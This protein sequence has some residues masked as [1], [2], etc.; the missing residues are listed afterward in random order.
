MTSSQ[1]E[2]NESS[3]VTDGNLR[4]RNDTRDGRG[5]ISASTLVVSTPI[6]SSA[7]AEISTSGG[8]VSASSAD[9]WLSSE[10]SACALVDNGSVRYSNS[11]W[12]PLGP[13]EIE[14]SHSSQ[15]FSSTMLSV[16]PLPTSS[17]SS[18][19][20]SA[21]WA[22]KSSGSSKSSGPL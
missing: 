5:A 13:S 3:S 17:H 11:E 7:Q 2:Q 4:R 20:A 15:S 10:L 9:M 1:S 6:V 18:P 21:Q 14:V 19:T 16:S 12:G 22:S 8:V